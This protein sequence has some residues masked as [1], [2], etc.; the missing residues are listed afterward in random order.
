MLEE[1]IFD[2]ALILHEETKRKFKMN[3]FFLIIS[4]QSSGITKDK[5]DYL[6]EKWANL[7][8][9]HKFQPLNLIKDYFGDEIAFYFAFCG[10]INICLFIISLIG[11]VFFICGLMIS[12]DKLKIMNNNNNNNNKTANL[13]IDKKKIMFS[14][15]FDNYLTPVYSVILCFWGVL[16]LEVWKHTTVH[17]NK[18]SGELVLKEPELHRFI[19]RK[20]EYLTKHE[21]IIMRY[22][23]SREK[24]FKTIIS[25]IILLFMVMISIGMDALAILYRIHIKLNVYPDNEKLRFIVGDSKRY[26]LLFF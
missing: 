25:M 18:E 1:S 21:N 19:K 10:T 5:R 7:T 20:K 11:I 3:K 24:N 2:D 26:Y 23:L 16:F 15:S 8:N 6:M 22:F 4:N 17:L 12:F 9:I 14:D 13:T